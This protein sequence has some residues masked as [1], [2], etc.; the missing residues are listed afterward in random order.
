MSRQTILFPEPC[1]ADWD[2]MKPEERGRFCE[3][4]RKPVHDLTQ[5]TPEEADQL[6]TGS[7]TPACVRASI[8]PDGQ[9]LTRPSLAGRMLTAAI[10]TPAIVA[11]L[12]APVKAG[13][14]TGSILGLIQTPATSVTVTITGQGVH[15]RIKSD[16][17][18]NFRADALPP[19]NYRLVFSAPR[20][21][22]W[23]LENVHVDAGNTTFSNS[24]DPRM[25]PPMPIMVT[26]GMPAPPPPPPKPATQ[27]PADTAPAAASSS[28][29]S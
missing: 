14:S 16:A 3:S 4:C 19:G 24:R 29:K 8:L 27:P 5:Y 17:G 11:A 7:A 9:V 26:A 21:K 20:A 12:A 25:P 23:T 6:L 13:D 2:R 22:S 18:G 1:H 10:V 15:R 28:A